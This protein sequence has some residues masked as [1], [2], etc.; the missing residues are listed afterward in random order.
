MRLRLKSPD[1]PIKKMMQTKHQLV[2]SDSRKMSE[3]KDQSIDLVVTSP[4][5][6]MIQ[7][8]DELFSSLSPQVEGFLKLSD[9]NSAFEAMHIELDKVWRELY[10][11]LK[12]GSFACVNIGDATR[13][14]GDRFLLY[15]NHSRIISFFFVQLV[16][17]A[18]Q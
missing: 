12:A 8:W 5:Y 14:I 4:P 16:L 15:S 1:F 17:I 7:M 18:C 9:G 13:T 11:V 6:P 10:R 2:V 3:I